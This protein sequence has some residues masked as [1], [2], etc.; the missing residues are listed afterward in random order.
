MP[1]LE[2]RSTP[3]LPGIM[4]DHKAP[5]QV[6]IAPYQEASELQQ[7]VDKYWKPFVGLAI[8]IAAVI[9]VFQMR[10][11]Q[12]VAH[13]QESWSVLNQEARVAELQPGIPLPPAAQLEDTASRLGGT[14]AEPWARA[15]H[16]ESLLQDEKWQEA[17]TA[18]AAFQTDF[19]GH[20][21]VE[22]QFPT[23]TEG[24]TAT[25]AESLRRS[26]ASAQEFNEEHAGLF[27]LPPLPEGSPRVELDTSAGKLVLGLYQD[28]APQ[29]VENFLKLVSNGYYDGVKFHRVVPGFMVQTGDPNTK[30]GDPMTWGQ[31]GP[32]YKIPLEDNNLYHF[33]GVLAAAKMG[34]DTESSGS[35]FYITTGAAHHLDGRHT[36]FGVL[37]EGD[38]VAERIENLPV[39]PATE[40]PEEPPVINSARIL[41]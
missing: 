34:Q 37:L 38:A 16:I 23:G 17:E 35:Q 31:G 10:A 32:D 4:A 21:L 11:N 24:Q 2:P 12:S 5:T 30:V 26:I 40:R 25:I 1:G 29:H 13:Q 33:K 36:V 9:V 14:A 41:E 8:L 19:A 18:I 20:P 28:R 3:D 15:L 7:A 22:Q 27:E 6:T 39:V